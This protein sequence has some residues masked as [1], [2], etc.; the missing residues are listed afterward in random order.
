MT[1]SLFLMHANGISEVFGATIDATDC[2]VSLT[3]LTYSV[4]S[5][6][7]FQATM[8]SDNSTVH[9]PVCYLRLSFIA[10]N[11]SICSASFSKASPT[12][13][14]WKVQLCNEWHHYTCAVILFLFP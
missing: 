12:K 5:A 14:P 6:P 13:A 11:C 7:V 2:L 8:S 9:T 1:S 10:E 3:H 4:G